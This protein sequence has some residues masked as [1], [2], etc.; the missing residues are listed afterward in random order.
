[1]CINGRGSLEQSEYVKRLAGVYAFFFA[2]IG[3]PIAY[4][5]FEPGEQVGQ[6]RMHPCTRHTR[7]AT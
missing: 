7:G 3:G 5:T 6:R 1:M 4:Q 2:F